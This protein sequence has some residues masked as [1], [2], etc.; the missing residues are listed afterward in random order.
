M[1]KAEWRVIRATWQQ[2]TAQKGGG[3][4]APG[5]EPMASAHARAR[6]ARVAPV[7]RWSRRPRRRASVV[8][9]RA[10]APGGETSS[11]VAAILWDCD[12]LSPTTDPRRAAVTAR[13]LRDAASRLGGGA[14]GGGDAAA[15]CRVVLFRAFGNP[16]TFAHP[17]VVDAL[18]RA[19]VEVIPTG[20]APDAADIALGAHLT[21]FARARASRA[22]PSVPLPPLQ[23]FLTPRAI[24]HARAQ[25]ES[26]RPDDPSAPDLAEAALAR[27][28][29]EHAARVAKDLAERLFEDANDQTNTPVPV[30]VPAAVLVATSDNDLVPCVRAARALGSRVVACGDYLPGVRAG[31]GARSRAKRNRRRAARDVGFGVTEAY[32][33]GVQAAAAA[34]PVARLKLAES[35]DAALVWDA[36]RAFETTEDERDEWGEG[37]PR[38]V[39]GGVVGVWRREGG[40][41]GVGRWPSPRPVVPARNQ[42]ERRER[43]GDSPTSRE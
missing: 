40:G 37:A 5:P 31:P 32:W 25:A 34:R 27:D 8:A 10:S 2:R 22:S 28:A 39:P 42:E 18:L 21:G 4:R 19:G 7:S 12:N 43:G 3:R 17:D 26:E 1:A 6:V 29:A 35:A 33:E 41:R 9:A 23:P 13:R 36:A 24:A 14:L 38:T 30:P 16:D 15:P 20:D 11:S